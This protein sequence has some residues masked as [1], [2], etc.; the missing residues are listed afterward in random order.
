MNKLFT[1]P[2]VLFVII[3]AFAH[4]KKDPVQVIPAVEDPKPT[5]GFTYTMPDTTKFLTYQFTSSSTNYTQ[6]L[7]QFGDDST[8]ILTSPLHTYRFPGKYLVTLNTMNTQGYWARKEILLNVV[9]PNFDATKVG[10]NYI[11]TIPGR[12]SVSRDNGGGPNANEGSLKVIDEIPTT[13]FFQSGFAGDLW[14]KYEMDTAV[15]AGAYT[16]TSGNDAWDRDPKTWTFQGSE[17]GIKWITLHSINKTQWTTS[18][19]RKKIIYHFDNYI[20]YKVY[21]I[22]FKANNGS[23]DFQLSDW[24]VNKKQP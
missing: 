10:V 6:L 9:D 20:A 14:L 7:W 13:K 15:V 3:L 23:R 2:S 16:L 17:D 21:R 18:E 11:R 5:A 24:T 12:F 4:C 19:R 1:I 8:S 22:N